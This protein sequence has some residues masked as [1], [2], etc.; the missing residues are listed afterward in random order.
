MM[1]VIRGH[2]ADDVWQQAYTSVLA[3]TDS[4][5]S[6]PSRA[7]DTYERLHVAFE[8]EDPRQ[9]WVVA[10]RPALNP[11]FG[12]AEVIWILA[13]SNDSA[14]LNYWFPNLPKFQGEGPTYPGAYGYRLRHQFGVDQLR[15]ACDALTANPQSRQVVLQ[16]WDVRTDLPDHTGTPRNADIPCNVVALLKVRDGRLEW[17]QIMRSNDLYRGLP[18]NI[19]QFTMLQEVMAGWLGV[20]VGHYH[21]WSDSLHVYCDAEAEFSCEASVALAPNSDS[22]A[23]DVDQGERLIPELYRR[24]V[25]LTAPDVSESHLVD[26]ATMP[27]APTGYQNL[28]RVLGAESARRRARYDQAQA[29]M[30]AC[31][32][33]QLV[34]V[35][36]AWWQRV[37]KVRI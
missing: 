37:Q 31:S 19:L 4:G 35:W 33:P 36:A 30:S 18:H 15:R 2:T 8:I 23:T 34:Q 32:N 7:G 11:A 13:G 21:H 29:L 3:V 12:I 10:R 26:L 27:D 20:K 28:L 5:T 22:L 9:R 24:L 25:E 16:L 17:T 1:E 6:Q 14:A